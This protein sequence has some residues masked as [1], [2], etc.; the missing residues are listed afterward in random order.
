MTRARL[1]A[2]A[3]VLTPHLTGPRAAR[4]AAVLDEAGIVGVLD[5][6][7]ESSADADWLRTGLHDLSEARVNFWDRELASLERDGT[8]LV[9]ITDVEYPRNLRLIADQPPLLFV[10]G[11]LLERDERALAVVGTR[12]ATDTGRA[13]ATR[14]AGELAQ[15]GVTVVSGL[16]EGIDTAAHAAALNVG[17]RTLAVFGTGIRTVFPK[18]NRGMARAIEGQGACLS[19]FWPAQG[20]ARW[21]FPLRNIVTS[22]LSLGTVVIEASETSGAR[23]QAQDALRHGKRLFLHQDVTSQPWA[24]KMATLPGVTVVAHVDQVV[25]A[26]DFD[27][28]LPE[29]LDLVL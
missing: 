14:L 21:T 29:Q 27:L 6:A 22:G 12:K 16:A 19:Q 17:G 20:G 25:E 26:V 10:R 24:I 2:L 13:S 7:V 9:L 15:R 1:L 18:T 5:A 28:A 4:L 11:T 3:E 8:R 23:L